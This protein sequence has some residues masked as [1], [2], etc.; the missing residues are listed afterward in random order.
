[1]KQINDP[2]RGTPVSDQAKSRP[3]Y[4]FLG[5]LLGALGFHNFYSGHYG[6]GAVKVLAVLLTFVADAR[7]GFYTGFMIIAIMT[8]MLWTLVE[9]VVSHTDARGVKMR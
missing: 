3:I 5:V 2:Q 6:R 7:T 8:I 9:L 4:V 1:M